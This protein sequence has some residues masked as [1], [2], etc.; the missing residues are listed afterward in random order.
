MALF[1]VSLPGTEIA[2]SSQAPYDRYA[3]S[4]PVPFLYPRMSLGITDQETAEASQF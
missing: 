1:G 3:A 4:D 2:K